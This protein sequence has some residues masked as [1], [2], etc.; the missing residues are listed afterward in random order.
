MHSS[1]NGHLSCFH[2]LALLSNVAVNS[3]VHIFVGTYVLITLAY[4]PRSGITISHSNSL[5]NFL[6]KCQS[7]SQM[8]A[9]F[10]I[11]I[12]NSTHSC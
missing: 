4:I 3:Y 6:R 9:P 11:S 1:I 8:A 5:F 7:V 2:S 12:S 10:Y